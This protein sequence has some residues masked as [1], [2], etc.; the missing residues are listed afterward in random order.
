MSQMLN[1]LMI[2]CSGMAAEGGNVQSTA[3]PTSVPVRVANELL[4][5]GHRYLDVRYHPHLISLRKI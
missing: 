3:A 2:L 5:A 4:Q 1:V